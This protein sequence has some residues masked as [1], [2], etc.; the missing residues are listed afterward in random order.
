[1]NKIV[2]GVHA[3]HSK[4]GIGEGA[5]GYIHEST[6]ARKIAHYVIKTL[7]DYGYTVKNTTVDIGTQKEVLQGIYTKSKG[8]NYNLSIHLNSG[9]GTGFETLVKIN[10]SNVKKINDKIA[11]EV[12]MH[13]RGVKVRN[14]LYVLNNLKNCILFE[15]GFVDR[16]CDTILITKTYKDIGKKIAKCYHE[17]LQEIRKGK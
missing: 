4:K 11:K 6:Y 3:G 10:D 12:N 8:C 1:M 15:C 2:I 16:L 17:Y 13:N 7:R 14:N 5:I 9:G